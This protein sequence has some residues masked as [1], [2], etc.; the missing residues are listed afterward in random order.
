M[1]KLLAVISAL[2]A[3]QSYAQSVVCESMTICRTPPPVSADYEVPG[4]SF[5]TQDS[6]YV[7]FFAYVWMS[8]GC[9]G[10]PDST[11]EISGTLPP[12]HWTANLDLGPLDD[13]TQYSVI[14]MF[15]GCPATACVDGMVGYMPDE[16][17]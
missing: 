5:D 13:G 3:A 11:S 14:W 15:D 1:K 10:D 16:C 12:G 9:Q 17:Q 6:G 8:N 2:V 7:D 4:L